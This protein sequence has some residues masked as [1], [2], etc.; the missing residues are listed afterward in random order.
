MEA[1]LGPETETVTLPAVAN[2]TTADTKL[3][4]NKDKEIKKKQIH[5]HTRPYRFKYSDDMVIKLSEFSKENVDAD[6]HE[7]SVAWKTFVTDVNMIDLIEKETVYL[8]KCGYTGTS[9]TITL[10]MYRS[11]KYYFIKKARREIEEAQILERLRKE[12]LKGKEGMEGK[13]KMTDTNSKKRKQ[14][15]VVQDEKKEVKRPYFKVSPKVLESMDRHI[16]EEINEVERR[17][18]ESDE[19][20]KTEKAILLVDPEAEPATLKNVVSIRKRLKPSCM[21]ESYCEKYAKVL[22]EEEARMVKECYPLGSLSSKF[23]KTFKNR[24]FTLFANS[25]TGDNGNI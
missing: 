4:T 19:E 13:E 15:E 21:Y 20:Y 10:K 23:K 17:K 25:K 18:V 16:N 2:K 22:Q 5:T 1:I 6:K 24:C 8:E 14:P 11:A 7:F 12:A 9:E 3:H